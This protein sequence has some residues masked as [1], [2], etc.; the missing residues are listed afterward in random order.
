VKYMILIYQ[1]PD[2]F[3]TLPEEER[4][5]IFAEVDA[6]IEELT[7]SGEWVG[8][9]GLAHPSNTKTVRVRGGVPAV[10]DGPYLEAK[11][12]FAGYCLIECETPE[13]AVE[14]AARWPDARYSGVELR[15]VMG[16]SGEE[17]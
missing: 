6:L 8:G 11:E 15:A 14:I 10:T 7:K 3:P 2:A 1:N 5:T 4:Q 17:M 16:T 13:R 9:A 12:Q